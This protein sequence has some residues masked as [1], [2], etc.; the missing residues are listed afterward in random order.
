MTQSFRQRILCFFLCAVLLFACAFL[1]FCGLSDGGPFSAKKEPVTR[2]GFYFDTVV[3]ITLYG[4]EEELA[5]LF[6]GVF[7]ICDTCEALL[8][9]TE[10]GSDIWKINHASGFPVTVSPE[11]LRLIQ[12][13]CS[14]SELTN[15]LIDPT[16]T[17]LT[18]LWDFHGSLDPVLPDA[19]ALREAC[20]HV[21]Y[22]NILID[23]EART[24]TLTDPQA[25][26]DLGFI[27]KG[28]IADR[29]RAYL[30]SENVESAMINL[31]GNVLCI[32]EKPDKAPFHVGI[33]YPYGSAGEVIASLTVRDK[34]IVTSGV[35][36]RY[37]EIDGTRYH[38][39]LNPAT[40]YPVNNGL[41]SVTVLSDSSEQGDALST[42]CFVL[43]L[44]DGM[45]LI[46]SLDGTEAVF[47]TDDYTLHYSSG[48]TPPGP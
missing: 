48:L 47:I 19:D 31:G 42:T 20:S 44:T 12:T 35:Y 28:Y 7:S 27:A 37:L 36:E 14:Y 17:P 1:M 30:L 15:G 34:S 11:T 24:V 32:G 13:A 16:V 3:T 29:I 9:R 25:R 46:E 45:A 4:N 8:S 21:D 43:G 18:E 38:H 41:L 10:Y 2:N 6:D 26:L 5:P 39:I 23:E 33:Q 22:R 40:G